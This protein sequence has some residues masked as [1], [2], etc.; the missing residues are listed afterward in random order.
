MPTMKVSV[1]WQIGLLAVAMSLGG[2]AAGWAQPAAC[3]K[4]AAKACLQPKMAECQTQNPN[5]PM[6]AGMCVEQADI[7]C[8]KQYNCPMQ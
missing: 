1:S 4:A 2:A 8:S 3:N 5:N 7:Q 6:K